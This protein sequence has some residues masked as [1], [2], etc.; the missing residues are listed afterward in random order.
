MPDLLSIFESP[1]SWLTALA[2]IVIVLLFYNNETYRRY[3]NPIGLISMLALTVLIA[4]EGTWPLSLHHTLPFILLSLPFFFTLSTTSL[5]DISSFSRTS[6]LSRTSRTSRLSRTSSLLSHLGAALALTAMFFG[7]PDLQKGQAIVYREKNTRI[8][9]TDDKQP[10][11][12]PFDIQLND[13]RIDYYEDHKSPKQ[14]TSNI[15]VTSITHPNDRITLKTSVNHP[16]YHNGY[17]FYQDSYDRILGRY[18][19][20]KVVRD[21]WYPVVLVG[22]ALLALGALLSIIKSWRLSR[23]L[24]V[25]IILT[26]IFIFVTIRKINFGHLMPALRSYWFVP[27]LIIYM[28]AYALM[29]LSLLILIFSRISRASR[30]SRTS[31]SSKN[32]F[33]REISHNLFSS[34]SALLIIGMLCG[35]VW[36]KQAWGDYWTW[37]AKENWA[38]VTW[39]LSIAATHANLFSRT[40]QESRTSRISRTS[41]HSRLQIAFMVL[42]FI[43]IQITWYGVN[44]LPSANKSLHTYTKNN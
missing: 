21:P 10:M 36:A 37:D 4:I 26:A 28:V 23:L 6:R 14:Y 22:F 1:L 35:A 42:S 38:A 3:A 11:A 13:F 24:P 8:A 40:S 18:S 7:A 43:A 41:S 33:S 5:N 19:V 17:Y 30:I 44:H 27:H 20:I 32:I 39:L 31:S 15:T 34:S 29:A 16:A 9:Y 12:L 25:A 2:F